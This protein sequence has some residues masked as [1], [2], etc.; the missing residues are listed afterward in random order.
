MLWRRLLDEGAYAANDI[1]GSKAVLDDGIERPPDLPQ[2]RRVA[3][4]PAH[5]HLGVGDRG[6]H[7]LVHFMRDRGRELPHGRDTIRMR[8]LHVHVAQGIIGPLALGQ[9]EHKGD[10]LATRFTECRTADQYGDPATIL[11]D[12]FLF[13]EFAGSR[14]PYFGNGPLTGR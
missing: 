5:R 14:R 2:V 6:G 4:E 11:P 1:A 13:E 8:E 7:G 3:A 9:V 12:I 10:G